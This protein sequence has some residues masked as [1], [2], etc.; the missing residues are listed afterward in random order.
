M[1]PPQQIIQQP[2]STYLGPPPPATMTVS[3]PAPGVVIP[4]LATSMA[5]V[6][7]T[8]AQ[9]GQLIQ[10]SPPM[11]TYVQ[12]SIGQPGQPVQQYIQSSEQ[13]I[14]GGQF[15]S[16]PQVVVTLSPGQ[17]PGQVVYSTIGG[18]PLQ[19]P[20]QLQQPP[21]QQLM[22]AQG[23]QIQQSQIYQ[24]PGQILQQPPP[25]Q[26]LQQQFAYQQQQQQ[27]QH[28]LIQQGQ[29]T[30][31]SGAPRYIQQP[32]GQ[33]TIQQLVPS[34]TVQLATAL[35][36]APMGQQPAPQP[37]QPV[38]WGG[39]AQSVP[40]SVYSTM[41]QYSQSGDSIMSVSQS[42]PGLVM[43]SS[44]S[45]TTTPSGYVY[46]TGPVEEPK[47]R[48]TEEKQEDKVPEGLLGYE[49]GPPHLT[50]LMVQPGQ[51]QQPQPPTSQQQQLTQVSQDTTQQQPQQQQQLMYGQQILQPQPTE[52]QQPLP[53]PQQLLYSQV[54]Q[55]QP[56]LQQQQPQQQYTI[57][58]QQQQPQYYQQQ[59]QQQMYQ[60]QQQQYQQQ[61]NQ[62]L[63]QN[64]LQQQQTQQLQQQYNQQYQQQQQQQMPQIQEQ[65]RVEGDAQSQGQTTVP[66]EPKGED[67]LLMPPPPPPGELIPGVTTLKRQSPGLTPQSAPEPRKKRFH[68]DDD[69]ADI[70]SSM[71]SQAK[72]LKKFSF[73]Q[74]SST[75]QLYTNQ[76]TTTY[77]QY[78][79]AQNGSPSPGQD[80]YQPDGTYQQQQYQQDP[81][82]TSHYGITS[83][84]QTYSQYSVPTSSSYSPPASS[85]QHQPPPP[86]P[87]LYEDQSS[88][89]PES[90]SKGFNPQYI[91]TFSREENNVLRQPPPPP[92]PPGGR[93][94]TYW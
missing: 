30:I 80:Q 11:Q 23:V 22:T 29:Q 21:P 67:K 57:V 52:L 27:Q 14:I 4:Q 65:A 40:G 33:T 15:V 63:Q 25:Q 75:P 19:H 78:G 31:I 73:N 69:D 26:Q 46:K 5:P 36:P 13:Q 41:Q 32:I 76:T 10:Q 17:Q 74:Y 20:V 58:S 62:Q 94:R 88:R 39:P 66:G 92:P 84:G 38:S 71:A 37:V 64:Q 61:Q 42:Q 93:S 86:P 34:A 6:M 68:D 9:P 85:T 70:P 54:V 43:S 18:Q 60:Q 3:L 35:P 47:R 89:S 8:Q 50:N 72:E 90:R 2:Q 91:S 16:Q 28:Q 55:Q 45:S 59:Q 53:Q 77:S 1:P 56:G 83:T 87:P 49:H 24:Q 82:N 12:H 44:T 51:P 48:F 79:A 7:H 81:Q